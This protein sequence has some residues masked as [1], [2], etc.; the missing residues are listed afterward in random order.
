[1]ELLFIKDNRGLLY[2]RSRYFKQVERFF[3]STASGGSCQERFFCSGAGKGG[4]SGDFLISPDPERRYLKK[5][6]PS[7]NIFEIVIFVLLFELALSKRPASSMVMVVE[8][9]FFRKGKMA[10]K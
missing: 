2:I 10:T 7:H 8:G 4:M 5:S 6:L 3:I 1:M 9:R